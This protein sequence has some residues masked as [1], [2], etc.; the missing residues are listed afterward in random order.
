[1]HHAY[2][3][4]LDIPANMLAII[5]KLPYRLRDKWRTVACDIQ[6][7]NNQRAT[8]KNMVDFHER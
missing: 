7:N 6:E 8:F 4:E 2:M 5:M 3:H 1:M